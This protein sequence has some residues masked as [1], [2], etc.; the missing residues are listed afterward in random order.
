M[1]AWCKVLETMHQH[2][3]CAEE[4]VPISMGI[5]N[6][7]K[8]WRNLGMAAQQWQR[9]ADS[10]ECLDRYN[11]THIAPTTDKGSRDMQQLNTT[12]GGEMEEAKEIRGTL[13]F[14]GPTRQCPC[15]W[16]TCQGAMADSCLGITHLRTAGSAADSIQPL[17]PQTPFVNDAVIKE[18]LIERK[19]VDPSALERPACSDFVATSK[20]FSERQQRL[21]IQV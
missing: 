16:R 2:S 3:G 7:D 12:E 11:I 8:V 9:M 21:H 14:D 10:A 15:C 1:E 4:A 20:G 13:G 19:D 18:L 17:Q 5:F 6:G